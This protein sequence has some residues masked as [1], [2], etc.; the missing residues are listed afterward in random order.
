[1]YVYI[2]IYVHVSVL[3]VRVCV[4]V[5]AWC[6]CVCLCLS[7]CVINEVKLIRVKMFPP[8]PF[9]KNP[10]IIKYFMMRASMEI[11]QNLF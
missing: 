10:K 8:K 6:V 5:C 2:H 11:F 4:C 3:Y 9:L 7:M 1:M